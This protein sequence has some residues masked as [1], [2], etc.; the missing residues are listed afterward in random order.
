MA[1]AKK[2]TKKEL[3]LVQESVNKLNQAKL[4]L[5]DVELNKIQVL[6]AIQSAQQ[7]VQVQ[8]VALEEKYG[9]VS[10]NLST[11]EFKENEQ[12]DS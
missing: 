1:K 5:A 12:A 9:S 6:T 7:Q 3:E 8:Q 2:I 10:I 11:G 4:A